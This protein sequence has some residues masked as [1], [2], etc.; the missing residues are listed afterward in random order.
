[1][2]IFGFLSQIAEVHLLVIRVVFLERHRY[3]WVA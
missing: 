3:T 1:M 2:I